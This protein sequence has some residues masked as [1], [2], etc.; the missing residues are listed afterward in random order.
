MALVLAAVVLGSALLS[1]ELAGWVD[2]LPRVTLNGLVAIFLAWVFIAVGAPRYL[3]YPGALLAAVLAGLLQVWPVLVDKGWWEK[4]VDLVVR[5]NAWGYAARTGG[6]ST[7]PLAFYLLVLA[8]AWL[9]GY[10]LGWSAGRGRRPWFAIAF[11]GVVLLMNLNYGPPRLGVFFLA[12]TLASLLLIVRLN[13]RQSPA[14]GGLAGGGRLFVYSS[15]LALCLSL[16]AWFAPTPKESPDLLNMWYKVNTP[17]TEG[18]GQLNRLFAFL[19]S[20]E[21]PGPGDFDRALVLRGVSNLSDE[22]VM[23]VESAAPRYWRGLS[24]DYYTGQGWLV[25]EQTVLRVPPVSRQPQPLAGGYQATRELTQT[26]T[27]LSPK[28]NLVFAAGQARKVQDM[29]HNLEASRRNPVSVD[30]DSLA[31]PEDLPSDIRPYAGALQAALARTNSRWENSRLVLAI[32]SQLPPALQVTGT[33]RGEDGRTSELQ[34]VTRTPA[35]VTAIYASSPLQIGQRYTVV[36]SVS[37]ASPEQLRRAGSDYPS[38]VTDRYLQLPESLSQRVRDLSKSI[39]E[40]AGSPYDKALAIE[41]YL[42]GFT[43]STSLPVPPGNVDR[44][45]YMLFTLRRGYSAYFSTTMVV[46]LRTLGIPARV[47]TGYTAGSYDPERDAYRIKESNAHGWVEVF[48]PQYGWIE[49][50]PTPSLPTIARPSSA[51]GDGPEEDLLLK[52]PREAEDLVEE[53]L[54]PDGSSMPGAEGGMS[55]W[56]LWGLGPLGLAAGLWY[57]WRRRWAG[58]DPAIVAYG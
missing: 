1:V 42:R 31:R 9:G 23:L 2:D 5:L 40:S 10:M 29:E 35:D 49:F 33:A 39:T 53:G 58:L 28:N 7:D 21:R 18:L 41:S 3:A 52:V 38:W 30:V 46:M 57:F 34:I 22:P 32:N 13:Q 50:E 20:K 25:Q 11:S 19:V 24:Y 55:L 45:D 51:A 27:I 8:F 43:Y 12:Y 48:Y 54:A 37:E 15:A 47:A 56:G 17:W 26:V 14:V 6:I 4:I 36:S 16:A 44:V